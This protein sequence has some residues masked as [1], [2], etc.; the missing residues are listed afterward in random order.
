MAKTH[1]EFSP[2]AS[3]RW[4]NCAG[5][6]ALCKDAPPQVFSKYAHEGT[7]AH[8]CL[9]FILKKFI[10]ATGNKIPLMKTAEKI[11]RTKWNDEMVDNALL[12]AKIIFDLRPSPTAKLLIE[13]K[14]QMTHLGPK[15]FGSLDAAWV[16]MWG[17]LVVIDYKYG[18]G[19]P[20]YPFY[21]ES[22][23]ENSQ[24]ML[25]AAGLAKKCNYEF[26]SVVL[27]IIQPRVWNE[28]DEK[29]T[30]HKTKIRILKNFETEIKKAITAAKTP[31]AKLVSGEWCTFCPANT[32]C[33]EISKNAMEKADIVFDVDTGIQATPDPKALTPEHL[34]KILDACDT[35]EKWMTAVREHAFALAERGEKIPGRKL[36]NKRGVRVWLPKA[37]AWAAKKFGARVYKREFLSPAQLE[38]TIGSEAKNFTA[39][40][41]SNISSGYTLVKES[42]KRDEV[43]SLLAFDIKNDNKENVVK[44]KPT[45]KG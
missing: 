44:L 21:E 27:V 33:P 13:T 6:V 37:E 45:N 5:S 24:L 11:A 1:S 28:N 16:E 17:P 7:Q 4:M 26:N 15:V 10:A 40:Y 31:K 18:A 20:V 22:Q 30:L 38:K 8:K 19:M 36:V 34:G 14:I 39:K 2:S 41:T 3:H 29:F 35:L 12:A 23:K 43:T 32:I 9:E 25:Y 42:D